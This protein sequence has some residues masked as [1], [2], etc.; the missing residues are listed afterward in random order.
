[1]FLNFSRKNISIFEAIERAEDRELFKELCESLGEPVLP[2]EIA[3]NLEDGLK[4]AKEIGFPVVLRPAF[5]LFN[6]DLMNRRKRKR[7]FHHYHKFFFIIG[8]TAACT[9]KS[10]SRTK[11]LWN[12]E[13][14]ACAF[15][16]SSG[17]C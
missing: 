13:K 4:A 10:K 5:T 2:S 15:Y 8:K 17:P 11:N 14:C 6:K 16:G 3:E 12:D 1:M 7:I 9:A